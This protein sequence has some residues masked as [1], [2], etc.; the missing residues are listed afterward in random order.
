VKFI[1]APVF[2][3]FMNHIQGDAVSGFPCR[4]DPCPEND[5]CPALSE[6]SLCFLFQGRDEKTGRNFSLALQS[7]HPD[8]W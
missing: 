6:T 4:N 8:L 5:P 2:K 7:L 3:Q 1:G